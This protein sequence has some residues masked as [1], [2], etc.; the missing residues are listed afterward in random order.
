[1]ELLVIWS[2]FGVAC[3]IIAANKNRSGFGW[4]L[5][6]IILG[7][8]GLLFALLVSKIEPPTRPKPLPTFTVEQFLDLETKKCPHCAETVK[9][10]ALKCRYCGEL[11]DPEQ[12]EAEICRRADQAAAMLAAGRLFCS[13]CRRY[14]AVPYAVLPDGGHGPWCPNCQ[15]PI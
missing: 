5:L 7:P 3:A 11:L 12:V 6:G 9:L 10:A 14:D 8:F 1:M 13:H 2:L 15:R 4:F